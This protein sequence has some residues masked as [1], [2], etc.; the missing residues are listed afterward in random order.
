MC[1]SENQGSIGDER[2]VREEAGATGRELHAAKDRLRRAQPGAASDCRVC[3][4]PCFSLSRL[5]SQASPVRQLTSREDSNNSAP[6]HRV[7][8]AICV[9]RFVVREDSMSCRGKL[10]R[11]DGA[12]RVRAFLLDWRENTVQRTKLPRYRA[13]PEKTAHVMPAP[14]S[15]VVVREGRA[16]LFRLPMSLTFLQVLY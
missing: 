8:S 11:L 6:E 4:N 13:T 5:T 16:F 10:M 14:Q 1:T 3:F 15:W 9:R 2:H 12:G 7:F